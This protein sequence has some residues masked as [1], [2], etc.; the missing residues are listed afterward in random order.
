M[1]TL[2][3]IKNLKKIFIGT[4]HHGKGGIARITRWTGWILPFMKVNIWASLELGS[5]KSTLA[6]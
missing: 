2:I 1:N 5:G 3:E 4:G 6:D